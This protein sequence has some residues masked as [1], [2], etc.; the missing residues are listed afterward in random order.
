LF[1]GAFQLSATALIDAVAMTVVGAFGTVIGVT[2]A[3][4]PEEAPVP[5]ELVA[6]TVNV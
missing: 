4:E 6:E 1:D 2:E 3:E 5:T